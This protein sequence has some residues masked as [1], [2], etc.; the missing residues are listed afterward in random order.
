MKGSA[1]EMFG[2]RFHRL[3]VM[4]YER[5]FGDKAWLYCVCDCGTIKKVRPS[6]VRSGSIQ[7]C[8]CQRLEK[9]RTRRYFT[10]GMTKSPEHRAWTAMKQRVK[11][12]G[13]VSLGVQ[14]CREWQDSFEAFYQHVG[15]RPSIVHSIDRVNNN[16]HYEPGNV[17]WATPA[18]QSRNK[19]DNR[20]ITINGETKCLGDWEKIAGLN[21]GVLHRRVSQGWP[22]EYL[23]APPG[24]F[25]SRPKFQRRHKWKPRR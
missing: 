11:T 18:Q 20:W 15:P 5:F 2:Q 14:V 24:A 3:T 21:K 23:L 8:G 6:N 12:P 13:Y 22:F 4:G 17:R 10:H 25:G 1:E 19:R 7:S 9:S 16:G